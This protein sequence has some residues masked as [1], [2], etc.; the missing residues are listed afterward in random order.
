MIRLVGWLKRVKPLSLSLPPEATLTVEL[1]SV[2]QV[3]LRECLPYATL[4]GFV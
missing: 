3:L 1:C 2:A 4:A